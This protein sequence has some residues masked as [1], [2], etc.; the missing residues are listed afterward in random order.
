MQLLR[1]ARFIRAEPNVF[2][3]NFATLNQVEMGSTLDASLGVRRPLLDAVYESQ[4][5]FF[6]TVGNGAAVELT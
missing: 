6:F 2:R 1:G 4:I 5:A 3:S